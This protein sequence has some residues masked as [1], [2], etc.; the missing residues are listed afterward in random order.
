MHMTRM[1]IEAVKKVKKYRD[2]H[3]LPFRK[4][5][6][7]LEK[8]LKRKINHRQVFRWYNYNVDSYPQVG[9]KA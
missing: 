3:N 9:E 5:A 8:E 6:K 1:N 7:L 2:K 4:I